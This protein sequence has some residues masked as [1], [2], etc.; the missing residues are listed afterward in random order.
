MT[1]AEC[2][3]ALLAALCEADQLASVSRQPGAAMISVAPE[4]HRVMYV[5]DL[6]S[7]D[8]TLIVG[9]LTPL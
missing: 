5:R 1:A 6:C 2:S 4:Q 7:L 8:L 3:A 9:L